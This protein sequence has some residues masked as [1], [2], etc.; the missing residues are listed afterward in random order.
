MDKILSSGK[1]MRK[2]RIKRTKKYGYILQ[3]QLCW[4]WVTIKRN[5]EETDF[6]CGDL[7][8]LVFRLELDLPVKDWGKLYVRLL[9][10]DQVKSNA[11]IQQLKN[12][13]VNIACK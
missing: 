5:L 13:G 6:S 1:I 3:N 8:T 9:T 2:Y 12:Y 11:A 10:N 4:V 7:E